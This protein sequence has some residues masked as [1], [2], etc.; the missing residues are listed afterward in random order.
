MEKPERPE[1]LYI[2]DNKIA[3]LLTAVIWLA[4]A[5]GLVALPVLTLYAGAPTQVM[6]AMWCVCTIFAVICAMYAGINFYKLKYNYTFYADEKGIYDYYSFFAAGFVPW[7]QVAGVELKKFDFGGDPPR[8]CVRITLDEKKFR[9]GRSNL[10]IFLV[11]LNSAIFNPLAL[12]LTF[13]VAKG[14]RAEI[15]ARLAAMY[16]YY[17][18]QK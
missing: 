4:A 2:S 8:S 15:Y 6:A 12:R 14:S 10:S 16:R 13:A 11:G 9:E 18:R 1:D 17:K 3:R 5:A 7:E